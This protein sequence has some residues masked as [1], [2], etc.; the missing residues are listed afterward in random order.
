[1]SVLGQCCVGGWHQV[2]NILGVVIHE[3]I[4]GQKIVFLMGSVIRLGL[5]CHARAI[6]CS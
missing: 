1:M 5:L 4:T 3:T 6:A 2:S